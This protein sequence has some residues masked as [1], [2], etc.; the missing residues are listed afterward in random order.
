MKFLFPATTSM[1]L[2]PPQ[3]A[4]WGQIITQKPLERS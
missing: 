3:S 2:Y 4:G 1:E